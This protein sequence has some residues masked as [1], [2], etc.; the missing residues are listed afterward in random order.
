MKRMKN[1]NQ[2][3]AVQVNFEYNKRLK[4]SNGSKDKTFPIMYWIPKLHKNPEDSQ[5]IIAS[6]NCLRKVLPK[7]VSNV[8]IL[9]YSQKENFC[10]KSKFLSNYNYF[11]V[12]QNIHPVI[13]NINIINRKIHMTLVLCTPH[14]FIVNWLRAYVMWLI[15]FLKVEIKQTFVFPK[16]MSLGK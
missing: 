11:W 12:L 6:I 1:K 4:R 15:L 16:I 3:E 14:F 10:C 2:E 13:E 7:T 9:I 5:F 8:F